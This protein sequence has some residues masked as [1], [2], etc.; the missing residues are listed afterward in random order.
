MI[1]FFFFLQGANID[2]IRQSLSFYFLFLG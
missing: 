1:L 2:K